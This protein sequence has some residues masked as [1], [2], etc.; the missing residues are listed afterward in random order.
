MPPTRRDCRLDDGSLAIAIGG[1]DE[2]GN[3]IIARSRIAIFFFAWRGSRKLCVIKP[4]QASA[5]VAP[6]DR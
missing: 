6:N 5:Q 3:D 1:S 4:A 2:V